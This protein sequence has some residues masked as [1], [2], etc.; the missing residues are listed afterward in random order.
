MNRFYDKIDPFAL[1]K[2]VLFT[3]GELGVSNLGEFFFF[4]FCP[5]FRSLSHLKNFGWS[6]VALQCCV[7]FYYITE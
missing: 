1:F 7:C 3:H 2:N 4:F 5:G 6:I